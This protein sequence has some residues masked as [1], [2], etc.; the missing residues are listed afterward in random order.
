MN[1]QYVV[2]RILRRQIPDG[3]AFGLLKL[4]GQGN[5]AEVAPAEAWARLEERLDG[6]GTD[7]V[8]RHVVE[9]GS[10]RHA[11]LGLQM[12]G[13]GAKRVTLVDLYAA[14]LNQPKHKALLQE[15]CVKLGLGWE[16]VTKRVR[17]LSGD[18]AHLPTPA[19]EESADIVLSSAVLEHTLSPQD[20]LA[21]CYAWLKPGGHTSHEID[22]RDHL[23]EFP[24]EMLTFSEEIW[25]RWL[26]P[27][28]GF[29]QNRWRLP[30]YLEAIKSARF[31][32]TGY[33][34]LQRD[35]ATLREILP[36]LNERFRDMDPDMLSVL[37]VHLYGEKP[38]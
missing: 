33:R 9:I 21:A 4:M 26:N 3:W 35:E 14:D 1:L 29:H 30:E 10:G 32:N 16:D 7:V 38:R 19:F 6:V 22:L 37:V 8:G 36:R 31:V 18:F 24:F 13:A 20:V 23:F 15:D 5:L 2:K 25:Q 17:I 34:V 11:R 28:R 27:K 12:L